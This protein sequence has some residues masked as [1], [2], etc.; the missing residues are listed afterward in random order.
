MSV[1][2]GICLD[3]DSVR[4]EVMEGEYT[5]QQQQVIASLSDDQISD[6]ISD[7]VDDSFWQAYDSARSDAILALLQLREAGLI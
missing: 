7:A 2:R 6:A 4:A 5:E 3:A 1:K